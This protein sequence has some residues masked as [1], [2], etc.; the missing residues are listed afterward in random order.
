MGED[1]IRFVH[2]ADTHLGYSA[3]RKIDSDGINLREKDI[4]NSFIRAIDYILE[5]RPDF[6]IHA[7]DLFDSVRPTNRAISIALEQMLRLSKSGI[8]TII[9]AGNHETPKLKETGHIFK[10]FD[11]LENIHPIYNSADKI[12]LEIKGKKLSIQAI[13]H[14]REKE[15]FME[16]LESVTLDPSADHNILV[17][18]GAVQAIQIFR[19][20]EFNEYIIPISLLSKGF[21]YVALGHYHGFTRIRNNIIYSGST[22]R[23]NFSESKERKGLVDVRLSSPLITDFVPLPTRNMIEVGPL[24]CKNLKPKD[25]LEKIR[26][27]TYGRDFSDSIVRLSLINIDP[28]TY[29]SIDFPSINSIFSRTMHFEIRH[30][31]GK[32]PE[33]TVPSDIII[34]DLL[35]EFDRFLE[36]GNYPD[37]RVLLEMGKKYIRQAEG[38]E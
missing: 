28:A 23:M 20:N 18:H 31:I 16:S 19:M 13:P 10:I 8:P 34:T 29:K 24:D 3:Y 11:H 37:K 6:V 12:E 38:E 2:L 30:S 9:V 14:S 7:G 21:D 25:I 15:D 4:Y 32:E 22:E 5:R 35:T 17:T 27:I 1:E 26:E 36:K 33:Q